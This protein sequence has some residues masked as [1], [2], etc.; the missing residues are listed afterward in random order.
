MPLN[1][2]TDFIFA[3]KKATNPHSQNHFFNH[4][5]RQQIFSNPGLTNWVDFWSTS[6]SS[7]KLTQDNN[8][9]KKSHYIESNCSRLELDWEIL[10]TEDSRAIL[11]IIHNI[12]KAWICA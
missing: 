1:N 11:Y 12:Y 5:I 8:C 7:Q 10:P 6:G 9:P 4:E 2:R 3:N